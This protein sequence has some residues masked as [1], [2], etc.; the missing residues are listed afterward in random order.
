MLF[1][2]NR[3]SGLRRDDQGQR[4][5]RPMHGSVHGLVEFQGSM[6]LYIYL[7]LNVLQAAATGYCRG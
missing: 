2:S 1:E 3:Q 6:Y 5:P 7:G 4:D